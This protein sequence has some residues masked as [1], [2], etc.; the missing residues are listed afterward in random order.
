MTQQINLRQAHTLIEAND[1]V[2][3]LKWLDGQSGQHPDNCELQSL[4]LDCLMAI[5]RFETALEVIETIL[6]LDPQNE[7]AKQLKGALN[8]AME[9]PVIEAP[10]QGL[11]PFGSAIPQTT[12]LRIQQS[13]HHYSYKGVQMVKD[14][15]DLA[16]YPLLIWNL[17]PGSIIEIGSKAGGSGLWLGDMLENFGFDAHVYSLD[18]VPVRNLSHARVSYL[19]GNGRKLE[20]TLT[21]D[22]LSR[23]RRPWLVIE[24]ADHVYETTIA[25]LN[26]FHPILNQ[27]EYIVVEDGIISDLYPH[28]FPDYSSGPHRALKEFLG[29]HSAEYV[30]DPEYCDFFGYNATWSSNG[31]LKKVI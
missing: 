7:K 5:G 31:F 3:A 12:L 4:R 30:I 29:V 10:K 23:C 16:L 6:S 9:R 28:S 14:P 25:V 21:P 22:F 27:G 20:E 24:D 2:A 15:F 8:S 18:V 26:F 17:R 19:E 1:H 11:R 13:A